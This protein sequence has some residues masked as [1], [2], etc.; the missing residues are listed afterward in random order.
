[1]SGLAS[2]E[3]AA[4][5]GHVLVGALVGLAVLEHWFLVLPLHESTLW[6]W[7]LPPADRKKKCDM[8]REE[9]GTRARAAG[10]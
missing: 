8:N 4:R 1:M 2:N 7:A 6:Q 9:T 10:L 5:T 3:A